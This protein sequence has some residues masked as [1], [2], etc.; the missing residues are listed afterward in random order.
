TGPG[1]CDRRERSVSVTTKVRDIHELAVELIPVRRGKTV[2]QC[3]GVFDLLH[4]GHI[5]HFQE[6]K[7]AGQIL[8]VTIT[9][10]RHVNKGPHRPVFTESLRAEAIAALD[11]VDYVAI[12][13]WPTAVEA[14]Q[15]L[16]PDVYA[17]GSDYRDASADH[18]GGIMLEQQA[19]EGGG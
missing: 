7:K 15:T 5:R 6:A 18:T 10:D 12:N 3:H 9:P 1:T 19:V 17:K 8:V 11:L 13:K 14:I 16:R 4:I 2:V